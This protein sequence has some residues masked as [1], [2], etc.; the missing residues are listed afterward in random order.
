MSAY[1]ELWEH[2]K[3]NTF[4]LLLSKHRDGINGLLL[5][6]L[7][8][9]D[10]PM[11]QLHSRLRGKGGVYREV[12]TGLGRVGGSKAGEREVGSKHESDG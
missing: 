5:N 7:P 3:A 2:L 6:N 9:L 11:E 10:F 1:P 8:R 4:S 12:W